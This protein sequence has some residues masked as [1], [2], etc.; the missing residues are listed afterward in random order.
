MIGYGPEDEYFVL[1]LTYNYGIGAYAHGNDF[2][3]IHIHSPDVYKRVCEQTE[4]SKK[5]ESNRVTILD[6]AGYNFFIYNEASTRNDPVN[7]LEISC[8]NLERSIGE[9]S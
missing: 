1:E 8:S 3:G 6:P 2:E 4:Y 9:F 7:C 5:Q